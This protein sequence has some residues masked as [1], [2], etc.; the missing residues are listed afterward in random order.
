[1]TVDGTVCLF[2]LKSLSEKKTTLERE[3]VVLTAGVKGLDVEVL[4]ALTVWEIS[5]LNCNK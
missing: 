5:I 3:P 2:L 4:L 1:M